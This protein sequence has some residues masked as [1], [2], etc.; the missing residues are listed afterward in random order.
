MIAILPDLTNEALNDG[1]IVSA[2]VGLKQGELTALEK[3]AEIYGV[4]K[5][6]IMRLAL[7]LFLTQ[8]RDGK[9]NI[10]D[11][12]FIP[13]APASKVVIPGDMQVEE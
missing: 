6:A 9:I 3:I 5:N 7:R 12:I 11:Y 13:P 2:G 8:V 4:K 1:R 10:P